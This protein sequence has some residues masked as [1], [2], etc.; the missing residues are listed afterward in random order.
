[1]Y[2][3]LEDFLE[4][5]QAARSLDDVQA[6]LFGLRDFLDVEHLVYHCLDASGNKYG[7]MTYDAPWIRRYIEEDYAR[8]DPVVQG[9]YQRFHPVDWK[10]LDW[11]GKSQRAFLG[12][13]L[14]TGV[15]NQGVSV[16]IRG[17]NGQFA[18]F[19]VNSTESDDGWANYRKEKLKTLIL[20]AHFINQRALELESQLHPP[21]KP[22]SPRESDALTL[23]ANGMNRSQASEKLGI[24]EHT[25]RVYIESA[26]FK[27][28]AANATHAV[29]RAMVRGLIVV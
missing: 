23:L 6:H 26:R 5:L 13:A 8:I 7:A 9:T 12:E 29:A 4:D 14:A 11:S 10:Q 20:A 19:S 24:S 17:P 25:L 16:P 28:G 3:E 22:L 15:G 21:T 18:L 27:L 2:Q 1:M